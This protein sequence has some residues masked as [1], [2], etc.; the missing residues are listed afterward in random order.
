[1]GCPGCEW[2]PRKNAENW[3]KHDIRFEDA[4]CVFEDP[5][6]DESLEEGDFDEVRWRVVGRVEML[7]MVVIYT[8]RGGRE[9]IMSARKAERPEERACYARLTP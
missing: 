6:R 4:C 7:V 1:M 5:F 8:E 3:R 2:D 9:R